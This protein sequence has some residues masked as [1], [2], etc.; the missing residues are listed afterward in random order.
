V[1]QVGPTELIGQTVVEKKAL[2]G[3]S[4]REESLQTLDVQIPGEITALALDGRAEDLFIGTSMV[5]SFYDMR[6]RQR[7]NLV[8]DV[9]VSNR[10][11]A[12]TT[13]GF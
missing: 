10:P 3:A 8:E 2:I 12:V 9:T 4:R 13:L 7:P 5:R 1:A 11:A 6:D